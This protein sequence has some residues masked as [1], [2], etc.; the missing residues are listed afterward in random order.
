MISFKSVINIIH[1][2]IVKINCALKKKHSGDSAVDKMIEPLRCLSPAGIGISKEEASIIIMSTVAMSQIQKATLAA[3]NITYNSNKG[4]VY[5]QECQYN[6]L[7][8]SKVN[9]NAELVPLSSGILMML[10]IYAKNIQPYP[11]EN[12][13]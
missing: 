10:D 11:I 4:P 8:G 5:P 3:G 1:R 9:V 13:L 7:S 6:R 12:K 2:V